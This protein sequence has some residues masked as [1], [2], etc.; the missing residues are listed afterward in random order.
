MTLVLHPLSMS[1][2]L[3]QH[4]PSRVLHEATLML[5]LEAA[6]RAGRS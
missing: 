4:A 3:A 6:R 2:T 1:G 5:T